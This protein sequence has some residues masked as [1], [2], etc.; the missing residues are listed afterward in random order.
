MKN[1]TKSLIIAGVIGASVLLSAEACTSDADKVGENISVAAENFE[2]Q[3]TII[4]ISGNDGSVLFMAE[5][6]CSFEYPSSQRVD[7]VCKYGPDE[8]RKHTFIK[9][10]RDSVAITQEQAIDASEYHTRIVLKPQSLL[11]AFDIEV[12]ED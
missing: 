5:G 1:K 4:G 7:V 6:R 11:P 3:R 12:G 8:Y 2:V 10:E 9:G